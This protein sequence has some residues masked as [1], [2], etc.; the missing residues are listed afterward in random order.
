MNKNILILVLSLFVFFTVII[1]SCAKD[2]GKLPVAAATGCDTV[3]Y[4]KHIKPIIDASCIS[5]HG[6]PLSGGANI[7]LTNYAQVKAAG[8]NGTFKS[9][10]FDSK[11]DLMPYNAAPLPQ[12]QKDL[13]TCW[14]NNGKKE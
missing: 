9:T 10:V 6:N 5:C 2:I 13:I 14:L 8:D 12:A 11:P 3:T 1:T 4:T 7:Y